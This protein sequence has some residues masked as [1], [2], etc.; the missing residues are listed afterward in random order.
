MNETRGLV[1]QCHR[2]RFED[3]EPEAVDR[4]KYLFLDFLGVAG[5]GSQGRTARRLGR[6]L[7]D[8][9]GA[10][11][12]SVVIGAGPGT[13][14]AWAALANGV[15][16]H[17]VEM[18]DVVNEASLHPGVIVFPAVLAAAGLA[19]SSGRELIAAAVAGY[20]T[21]IRLGVALDPAAHYARGFHP[22]STCGVFGAAVA[23]GK[24]LGLDQEGLTRALGIAG[25]QA[26]GSLE[27]LSDGSETK[28]FNAGWAAHGGLVAALLARQGFSGPA[29]IIE[30]RHGFL[31]GYSDAARADRVLSGWG[32][33]YQVLR[34]SI[35]PHACCRYKQGPIDALLEIRAK[36][37]PDPDRIQAVEVAVLRA[38]QA[39]VAEPP[40]QKRRPRTIVDAQFSMP[41]GVAVALLY[42]RAGIE[43][44][45]E[46]N[47]AS[48]RVRALMDKVRCVTDEEIEVGF[49]RRWAA[50]ARLRTEAGEV[51]EAGLAH[52]KGDPEN[53]LSWEELIEKYNQLSGP[54]FSEKRREKTI[55]TVRSLESLPDPG[56]LENLLRAEGDG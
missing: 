48:P 3:L 49:P 35:K 34:T 44:Y 21:A 12:G 26:A 6:S 56:P 24:L 39:L 18:D 15:A 33:P 10:Q 45:V 28:P 40:E 19:S 41:F 43:T 27:F 51:H 30:G 8:L 22:T 4:T 47:L 25:S 16:A 5:R 23:A 2:I 54:V 53:P 38:G 17:S 14:P 37:R 1:E 9:G 7:E 52:P 32:R 36:H 11:R 46:E 55:R 29:T 20:E 50:K 42:G 13:G 31:Q